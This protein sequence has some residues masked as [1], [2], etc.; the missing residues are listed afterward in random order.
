MLQVV[1]V[2]GSVDLSDSEVAVPTPDTRQRTVISIINGD[3]PQCT[4]PD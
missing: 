1:A 3:D 2:S 4:V